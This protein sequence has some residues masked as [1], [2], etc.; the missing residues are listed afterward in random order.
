[1]PTTIDAMFDGEVFRPSQPVEL[2]PNTPVKLTVE[3]AKGLNDNHDSSEILRVLAERYA[4]GEAAT[5]A[6]HD[7]HQP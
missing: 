7:E 3:A 5:A 2:K 4:S 1:M 6:R